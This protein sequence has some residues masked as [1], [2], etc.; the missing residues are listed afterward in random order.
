MAQNILVLSS[1][2]EVADGLV[3]DVVLV[4]AV[5]VVVPAAPLTVVQIS[6]FENTILFL[7]PFFLLHTHRLF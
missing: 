1:V 2:I 3:V 6:H 7:F 4:V 5:V